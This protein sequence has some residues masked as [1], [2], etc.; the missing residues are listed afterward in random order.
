MALVDFC[1]PVDSPTASASWGN[2]QHL[3]VLVIQVE[4]SF[5]QLAP[6]S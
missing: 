5:P 1:H 4:I 6:L 2:Q 3:P